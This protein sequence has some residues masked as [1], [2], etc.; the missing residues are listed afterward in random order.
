MAALE[1][2]VKAK[3]SQGAK[4]DYSMAKGSEKTKEQELAIE[5]SLGV[6]ANPLWEELAEEAER[7]TALV[8]QLKTMP[9]HDPKHTELEGEL[10]ASL[11][12]IKVH[13]QLLLER[14]EKALK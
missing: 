2:S 10:Y 5:R 9:P 8:R 6:E 7:Y 11:S 3:V 14:A 1:W 13:A 12:H 4:E